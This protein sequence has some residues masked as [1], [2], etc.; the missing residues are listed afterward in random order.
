MTPLA[1]VEISTACGAASGSFE[2]VFRLAAPAKPKAWF[3]RSRIGGMTTA[4]ASTPTISAACCFH[5]VA[6]T[7]WPVFRSCRLSL[8]MV[9]TLSSTAVTKRA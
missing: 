2:T 3:R 8:A 4:P 7:S 6:S 1:S 5:G 9:A